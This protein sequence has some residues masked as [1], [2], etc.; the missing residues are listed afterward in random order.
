MKLKHIPMFTTACV[1][2]ILIPVIF[3]PS[4]IDFFPKPNVEE[5]QEA[6]LGKDIDFVLELYGE[7]RVEFS[8]PIAVLDDPKLS[9]EEYER[10]VNALATHGLEYSYFSVYF[11]DHDTVVKV[12]RN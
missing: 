6:L 4:V 12:T 7:P 2:V 5:L 1:V 10:K 9:K 8:I 3:L 11:N